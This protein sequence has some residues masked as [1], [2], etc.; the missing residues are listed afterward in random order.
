[1]ARRN[2]NLQVRGEGRARSNGN[3]HSKFVKFG[4]QTSALRKINVVNQAKS[5]PAGSLVR[6]VF[7]PWAAHSI[8]SGATFSQILGTILKLIM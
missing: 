8:S 3:S 2:R 4:I 1:M 6:T 7:G 5:D